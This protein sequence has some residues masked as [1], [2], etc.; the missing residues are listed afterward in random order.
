MS[1][2]QLPSPLHVTLQALVPHSTP[3]EHE[4]APLQRT[5][6]GRF[7]GHTTRPEQ[8]PGCA[9]SMMHVP[10]MHDVHGAGQSVL[11]SISPGSTTHHP[12]TQSRPAPH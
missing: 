8:A 3:A 7:A 2:S 1:P 9:Q 11:A 12:S 5:V 6:H 10:F 4:P